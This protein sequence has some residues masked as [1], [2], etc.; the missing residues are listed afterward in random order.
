MSCMFQFSIDQTRWIVLVMIVS[1]F[2]SV[3]VA[4]YTVAVRIIIFAILPSW[5][6]ASAAATLVGQNLGA[7]KPDRAERSVWL[8][9]FYN[10]LFLGAVGV[11]LIV[12]PEPIIRV[13]TDD[14]AVIAI[15]VDCLRVIS[16]GIVEYA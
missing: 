11:L 7:G 14:P 4:G 1:T 10:M 6:L 3:A 16:Y 12:F 5:G 2:G 9:T 8:T 13:F 15:G